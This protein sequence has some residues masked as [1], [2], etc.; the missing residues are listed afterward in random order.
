VGW[1]RPASGSGGARP[2]RSRS[3]PSEFEQKRVP[4]ALEARAPKDA[5]RNVAPTQA[6][7][8]NHWSHTVTT[9]DCLPFL[10]AN[11]YTLCPVEEVMTGARTSEGVYSEYCS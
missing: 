5:W 8:T 2:S 11:G 9:R 3:V 1:S 10:S 7:A 6:Y 4:G